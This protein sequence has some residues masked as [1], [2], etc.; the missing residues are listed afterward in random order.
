VKKGFL[1][2]VLVAFQFCASRV[3]AQRD[4][5]TLGLW[6]LTNVNGEIRLG[7]SYGNGFTN[8]YGLKDN[9][10]VTNLYGGLNIHTGSYLWSPN[11]LK[12]DIDGAYFPSSNKNLYQIF[13]NYVDMMNLE[14]LHVGGTLLPY[15]PVTLSGY[16]NTDQ[17]Y[18]SRENLTDIRTNTK[19][20]GG[21]LSFKPV[22]LPFNIAFNE[23]D[24]TTKELASGRYYQY[25]QKNWDAHFSKSFGKY[26]RYELIV[27]RHDYTTRTSVMSEARSLYN[28]ADF[29]NFLYFDSAKRYYLNSEMLGTLQYGSGLGV[30]S[31]K[32][33][34]WN[35]NFYSKLPRNFKFN[36]GYNFQYNGQAGESIA[37]NNIV[38]DFSHQLYQSLHSDLNYQFTSNNESTYGEYTN[39]GTIGFAYTK[40]LPGK[41]L[42][43]VAE[44]YSVLSEKLSSQNEELQVINEPY[45]LSDKQVIM[46]KRPHVLPASIVVKDASGTMVYALNIDYILIL[47]G[48][49]Y[50]IQRIPGGM[51]AD[52]QTV[53]LNY[54]AIQPGNIRF[55]NSTNDFAVNVSLFG[56][57]LNLYY[58]SLKQ[59][60]FDIVNTPTANLNYLTNH[61]YGCRLGYK[62]IS[63]GTEYSDFA[64]SLYP[65]KTFRYF[66]SLQGRINTK[67][68]YCVNFNAREY[69]KMAQDS[70]ARYYDDANAMLSYA[71]TTSLKFDLTGGYVYQQGYE[72]DLAMLTARLKVTKLIDHYIFSGGFDMF[73]RSYLRNQFSGYFGGY[74]QVSKRF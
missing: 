50:Q 2:I 25:F 74:I 45:T 6:N 15:K 66:G 64:S 5:L 40:K 65:Y 28:N 69:L 29:R 16:Y 8:L 63:V 62:F 72:I 35:E 42:L 18:D 12:L 27:T 30:D 41:G 59:S 11:F 23:N 26:N 46:L 52:N 22:F 14:R 73:N 54:V 1:L 67:F 51:I 37:I 9:S 47:Q 44:N 49:Y 60:Y 31:Y 43:T 56:Q 68:T 20:Y 48:D 34:K 7:A 55:S 10:K 24:W 61:I 33:F 57:F 13:P 3:F 58:S 71:A 70:S 32:Q 19:G 39:K 17:S 21:M 38:A 36:A 53:Y 4:L